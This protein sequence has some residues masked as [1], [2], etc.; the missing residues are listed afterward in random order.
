[1]EVRP[2][3]LDRPNSRSL[4]VDIEPIAPKAAEGSPSQMRPPV[5]KISHR[6]PAKDFAYTNRNGLQPYRD[7]L[8]VLKNQNLLQK[9][10]SFKVNKFEISST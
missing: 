10:F 7:N 4:L 5:W 3:Y 6:F 8:L 2:V 9:N 1:M